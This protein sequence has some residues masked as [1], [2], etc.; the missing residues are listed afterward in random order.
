MNQS[1]FS[2]FMSITW[3]NIVQAYCLTWVWPQVG[4]Y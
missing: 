4:A 1:F 2:R 3:R